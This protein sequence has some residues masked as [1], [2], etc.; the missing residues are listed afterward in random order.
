MNF[1]SCAFRPAVFFF[2]SS[3]STSQNHV[4]VPTAFHTSLQSPSLFLVQLSPPSTTRLTHI[5]N[6]TPHISPSPTMPG[7]KLT[8]LG[9]SA[10]GKGRCANQKHNQRNQ[11]FNQGDDWFGSCCYKSPSLTIDGHV[12]AF[13][14]LFSASGPGLVKGLQLAQIDSFELFGRRAGVYHPICFRGWR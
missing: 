13:T 3:P 11:R 4:Y 12:C 14:P 8:S 10:K 5:S 7:G 2:F 1:A 6:Q 9:Q